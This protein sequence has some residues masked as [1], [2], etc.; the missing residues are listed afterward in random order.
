MK[1]FFVRLWKEQIGQ[2]T[3][4]Y[5]LLLVMVA[6]AMIASTKKLSNSIRNAYNA[7]GNTLTTAG[8]RGGGDNDG[9]RDDGGR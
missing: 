9:G 3:T 8:G 1:K 7:T 6:L 4:E 2:D 5:A